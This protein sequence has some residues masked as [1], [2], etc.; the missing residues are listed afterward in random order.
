MQT[1]EQF[2]ENENIE[3]ENPECQTDTDQSEKRN[4][5]SEEKNDNETDT[6]LSNL[7]LKLDNDKIQNL[8]DSLVSSVVNKQ[9]RDT[10]L[11]LLFTKG[12]RVLRESGFLESSSE[13][14]TSFALEIGKLPETERQILFDS[15]CSSIGDH[16]GRET[17]LHILFWKASKLVREFQ[18]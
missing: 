1:E 16:K 13:N 9:S 6:Y 18:I 15:V 3:N 4:N 2:Q 10:V 7:I 5:K 14:D 8:F 11:H 12:I 17:V